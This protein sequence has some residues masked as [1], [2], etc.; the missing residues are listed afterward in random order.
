MRVALRITRD[1]VGIVEVIAGVHL[2]AGGKP[3]SHDDFLVIV[4]QRNLDAVDLRPAGFDDGQCRFHG[5]GEVVAAPVA[6][7]RRIEHLAK[8]VQDDRLVGLGE[9]AA[10]DREIVVRRFRHPYECPAR[11]Q[12]HPAAEFLD[13]VKLFEVGGG[14]VV[15]RSR[16]GRIKLLGAAPEKMRPA[17]RSRI[18]ERA[19]DQLWAA[20]P[21]SPMPRWAVSIA[22]AMPKPRSSRWR[23]NAS[24]ASQSIAGAPEGRRRSA[25][26]RQHG[27]R[28][29]RCDSTAPSVLRSR[30]ACR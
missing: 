24:V 8:P 2:D 15:E 14:D 9:Y 25:D 3:P 20:L 27:Q 26:R 1:Q 13:G 30:S 4:E 18:R 21:W 7:E 5:G 19:A 16:V 11:H 6:A 28:R 17:S 29:K 22:S 10:V 12:D 23:R